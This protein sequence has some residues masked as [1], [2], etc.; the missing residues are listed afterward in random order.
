MQRKRTPKEHGIAWV[1]YI[2]NPKSRIQIGKDIPTNNIILLILFHKVFPT[3]WYVQV[4][5]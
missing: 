1:E 3:L 4:S 2:I 5:T